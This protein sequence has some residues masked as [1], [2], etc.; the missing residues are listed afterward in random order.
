[1][2]PANKV[3]YAYD[4]Y[5]KAT[6]PIKLMAYESEGHVVKHTYDMDAMIADWLKDRLDGK[7]MK[8]ENIY[9]EV[10]GREVKK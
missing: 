8:S 3:E 4:F 1:M 9:V 7:P 6:A 2:A 10:S 5:N